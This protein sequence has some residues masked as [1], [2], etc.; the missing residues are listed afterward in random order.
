MANPITSYVQ[1]EQPYLFCTTCGRKEY[2]LGTLNQTASANNNFGNFINGKWTA[3]TIVYCNRYNSAP[4]QYPI[5]ESNATTT[6]STPIGIGTGY[7]QGSMSLTTAALSTL[8]NQ[9]TLNE[10]TSS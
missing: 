10:R 4:G 2:N 5:L 8:N 7:C 9:T 3:P 6:I 1:N